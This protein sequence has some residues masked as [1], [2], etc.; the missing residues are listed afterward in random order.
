MRTVKEVGVHKRLCTLGN[1]NNDAECS[2]ATHN[3]LVTTHRPKYSR[4][5]LA[6]LGIAIVD[7]IYLAC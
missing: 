4:T 6:T 7:L 5:P 1:N 3:A 2:H